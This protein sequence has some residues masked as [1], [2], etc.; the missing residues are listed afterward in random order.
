MTY[1]AMLAV[2]NQSA[3]TFGRDLAVSD[4]LAICV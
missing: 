4:S 2:Y 3:Y 1:E